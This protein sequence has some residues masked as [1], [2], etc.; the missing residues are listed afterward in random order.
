MT[1][2]RLQWKPQLPVDGSL[3]ARVREG[4]GPKQQEEGAHLLKY[5]TWRAA[6]SGKCRVPI[7]KGISRGE[8]GLQIKGQEDTCTDPK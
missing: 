3:K 1:G 4:E 8:L 5:G 2:Q 7:G 6:L